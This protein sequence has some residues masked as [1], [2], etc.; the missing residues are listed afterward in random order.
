FYQECEKQGIKPII[1][2]EV[3]VAPDSHLKK[4]ANSQKEAS[5]HLT[6]LAQN[7]QGY[8]NLVR[9]VS[10]AHLDGFYYKPRID[11]ELLAQ[12]SGGLIGLSG[13]LKG[14]VP[15]AIHAEEDVKKARTLA[16]A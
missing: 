2:C 12:F 11:K 1:G 5:F 10:I 7:E 14:E 8:K 6:L 9:L 3:Y 4:S 15:Y 16:A 13:C